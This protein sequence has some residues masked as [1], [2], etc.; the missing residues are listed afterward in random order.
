MKKQLFKVF[1]A[2]SIAVFSISSSSAQC[3][4]NEVLACKISWGCSCNI[5]DCVPKNRVKTYILNGWTL[6]SPT[7]VAKNDP[8]VTVKNFQ[9]NP[10]SNSIPAT[11]KIVGSQ[12]K[13]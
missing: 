3:K 6:S 5:C 8:P 2:C 12:K 9:A 7:V 13:I 4:K 10:A 11:T 1:L